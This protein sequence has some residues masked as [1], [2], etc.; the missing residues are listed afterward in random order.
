MPQ[1]PRSPETRSRSEPRSPRNS[2]GSLEVEDDF[3]TS[4]PIA[5]Q[6]VKI[7]ETYLSTLLDDFLI[8][9]RA[10]FRGTKPRNGTNKIAG[11]IGPNK[12]SAPDDR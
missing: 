6:E 9:S 11:A 8:G 3:S 7:V 12:A 10:K 5:Y 1:K 2:T 4:V